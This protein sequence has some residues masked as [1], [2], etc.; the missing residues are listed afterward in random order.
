MAENIDETHKHGLSL[1]FFLCVFL[2]MWTPRKQ[3][4]I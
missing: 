4:L 1:C 2:G 3:R